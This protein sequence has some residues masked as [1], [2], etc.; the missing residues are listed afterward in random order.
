MKALD[1]FMI[2]NNGDVPLGG[3]LPDM[4]ATTSFYIDLQ[5]VYQKKAEVDRATLRQYLDRILMVFN[6]FIFS[7]CNDIMNVT[8]MRT[9]D[10]SDCPICT[11]Y[12][13]ELKYFHSVCHQ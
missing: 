3:Q 12:A 10:C 13:C 4:T 2:N 11:S 7:S 5:R 9:R 6:C 1:V 8:T